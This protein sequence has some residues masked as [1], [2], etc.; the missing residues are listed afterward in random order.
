MGVDELD[1]LAV[2]IG[3]GFAI[4]ACLVDHAQAIVPI[5][6]FGIAFQELARGLLGL[7][8][9][10]FVYEV[11]DSVGVVGQLILVIKELTAEVAVVMAVIMTSRLSGAG[12]C[13]CRERRT[14][15]GLIFR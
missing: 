1:N 5:V 15:G 12:R 13:G 10:A 6:D 2:A 7:I 8:E 3:R 14:L 11:D 4:T 9:L